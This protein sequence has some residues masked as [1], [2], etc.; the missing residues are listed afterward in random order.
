[1]SQAIGIPLTMFDT[2]DELVPVTVRGRRAEQEHLTQRV[3][4]LVHH[5]GGGVLWIDGP[6]AVGKSRMLAFAADEARRAGARVL[7]C[8]GVTTS[9]MTPMAPLLDALTRDAEPG[10]THGLRTRS[11]QQS[12]PYWLLHEVKE[13]LRTLARERPLVV[14]IDDVHHCD[15][16]TQQAVRTLTV[17][18]ADLPVLWVLATRPHTGTAAVET[19]RRDLLNG[20]ATHLELAPLDPDAVRQM[21]EDL[22]GPNAAAAAAYLDCLD[23]LPGAVRQVCAHLRSGL[24]A[25]P[26]GSPGATSAP[27]DTRAVIGP[28]VT[29]RLDQLSEEGREVT[30]IAAVLG[31]RLT[32]RHLSRVLGR[33]ESALLRPLREVLAARLLH[34]GPEQLAFPHPLVREILAGTLPRPVR[35]SV[36]RRSIDLQI[37]AGVSAVSLAPGLVKTAEPGDDSAVQLLRAAARELAALSPASA[38]VYLQHA[39]SLTQDTS[40][41]HVRLSAEL[42]PLLWQTGDIAGARDL[43]HQVVQSSPDPLTHAQTCLQLA[44]MNSQFLVAQPELHVRRVHSRR[45]VPVFLKDQLLSVTLLNRLLA[46]D[47]DCLA[48]DSLPRTHGG[49]PVSRLTYRTLQSMAAGH[50]QRWSDALQ[51]SEAAA[52]DAAQLDPA[53]AAPLAEVAVSTSW[54]ASLLSLAGK[55]R[56]AGELVD[57]GLTEAQQHGRQAFVPLWRTA[58]ARLMLD[59][60]R[61]A[62]AAKELTAAEAAAAATRTPWAAEA[63]ALYAL[64]RVAFHTGDDAAIEICATKAAAHLAGDQPQS[65]HIGAWIAVLTAVYRAEHLS[66][67]QL[68]A[69]LGC[70]RRGLVHSAC[71]DPGDVVLLVR[72]ALGRGLREPALSAV[73]FAEDRAQRNPR[74]P[75]FETT[76]VHARGLLEGDRARLEAAAERY[77][78]AR[79]LLRAH[80]LED[81][82]EL[83]AAG[84][85]TTACTR[86][87]EAWE[88]YEACGA[89]RE[90]R[91]TQS[92]LR[93]LGVKPATAGQVPDERWRGLTPSELSVVQ[94]IAHG[95]TN[96]QAA[97][98]LFLSPHTVNTHV[99]H[100]FEKLGIRSRVQLARLYLREVDQPAEA[101]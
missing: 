24:S 67:R 19:L 12:D 72:A 39:L 31:D 37:R 25:V 74:F 54:C 30:L 69:A 85:D 94:L 58:R 80:A 42:L 13:R 93:K 92:K 83:M 100:T 53:D 98:R 51:H 26:H 84:G 82:G 1:M 76:A 7:V 46:G 87:E 63:A 27:T 97:E 77:G 47:A 78:Q 101:A 14:V 57:S 45:D 23:G 29:R 60:G 38:T 70:L 86:L 52:A 36:R 40:P 66:Q 79:P 88:L 55:D 41:R 68:D 99:R 22:L 50:R 73:R 15:D 65:R 71:L 8:A 62:D 48:A 4:R 64:A 56:S 9:P 3:R 81:A 11:P 33:P 43:A 89:H 17:Q 6:A 20:R 5:S 34:A 16:L 75:L 44:R 18:L 90:S 2:A 32:V 96:R 59:S 28:V 91:R 61:L 95:A 35:L 10:F 21:T 49:H